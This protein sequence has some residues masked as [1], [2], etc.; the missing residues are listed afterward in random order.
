MSSPRRPRLRLRE[1]GLSDIGYSAVDDDAGIEDLVALLAL[2]LTAEDAAESGQ[3][4]QISLVR[5]DDQSHVGHEQHHEN[6][7]E[8]LGMPCGHTAADYQGEEVSAADSE[9]TSNSGADETL[10]ADGPQLPLEQDNSGANDETD[11][12]IPLSRQI[13]RLN[14]KASCC[15]YKDKMKKY[16]YDIPRYTSPRMQVAVIPAMH[17]CHSSPPQSVNWPFL[18][19]AYVLG[20]EKHAPFPAGW[21]W[22]DT[23]KLTVK[24]YTSRLRVGERPI[25]PLVCPLLMC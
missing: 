14:N 17:P 23:S 2:L 9:N 20:D 19:G 18:Y 4:Q 3:V 12:G 25:A 11:C 1:S 15:D 16:K 24:V 13:E 7:Q 5:S 22:P 10:E 21:G 8:T 6:L